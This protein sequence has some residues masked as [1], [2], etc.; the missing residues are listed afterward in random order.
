MVA[1]DESRLSCAEK[2][3]LMARRRRR[4]GLGVPAPEEADSSMVEVVVSPACSRVVKWQAV[5][6]RG[7]PVL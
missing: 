6:V 2:S 1:L 7:L 4:K 3:S 5:A